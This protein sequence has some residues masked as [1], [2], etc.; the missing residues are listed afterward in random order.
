MLPSSTSR[1]KVTPSL[2]I[3]RLDG[4]T[5]HKS[6]TGVT[7]QLVKLWFDSKH[8]SQ[9]Y[10]IGRKISLVDAKLTAICPP[11][12]IHRAP[13][14]LVDRKYWKASE[15]RAFLFY[16]LVILQGILL[17]QSTSTIFFSL[18]MLSINL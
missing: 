17:L 11:S 16:S 15:W 8:H 10:Y 1:V 18:C 12:E 6:V 13:R 2:N 5:S 4:S 7:R 3:S 9:P 14:S